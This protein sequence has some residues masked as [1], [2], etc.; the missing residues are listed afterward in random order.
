[1]TKFFDNIDSKNKYKL[2]RSFKAD[3]YHFKEND[4]IT[5]VVFERNI[6]ALLISGSVSLIR[7]S[8]NGNDFVID[9]IDENN[10][11]GDIIYNINNEDYY[12]IANEETEIVTMNYSDI[13]NYRGKNK[14]YTTLIK[15]LFDIINMK[16]K[17]FNERIDIMGRRG[18]RN[19]LLA[20]FDMMFKKNNSRN[21]YL[22]YTYT[23]MADYIG[24]DRSA[25]TREL[26]I[27]KDEGF[28]KTTGKRITL[29]Y[30]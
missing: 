11:I 1:M 14:Y 27:L 30:K 12:L 8:E 7:N 20:Y 18:I 21:I 4:D 26:K 22:P 28:I 2:L 29:L 6:I 15:N 16:A 13:I 9:R 17:L 19:K 10:I 5:H 3:T 25:M 24:V 23:E